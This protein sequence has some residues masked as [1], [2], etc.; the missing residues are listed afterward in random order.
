MGKRWDDYQ[1][2]LISC[3]FIMSLFLRIFLSSCDFLLNRKIKIFNIFRLYRW[4][5]RKVKHAIAFE[6]RRENSKIQS[7][8]VH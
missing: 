4:D 2:T 3:E 8:N 1:S 7:L 5:Y 6:L